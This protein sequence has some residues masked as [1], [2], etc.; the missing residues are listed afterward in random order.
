MHTVCTHETLKTSGE[1]QLK[2]LRSIFPTFF[3][4]IGNSGVF[5]SYTATGS[6]T[7]TYMLVSVEVVFVALITYSTRK[8]I[9][10][11]LQCVSIV[12]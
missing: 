2:H 10:C 3:F 7:I 6:Q 5:P 11:S 4:Y 12:V 1:T 9:L 8:R